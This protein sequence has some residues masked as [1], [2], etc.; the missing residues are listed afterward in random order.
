MADVNKDRFEARLQAIEAKTKPGKR[1][2]QR[3]T[4]DGLVVDIVKSDRRALLPIKSLIAAAVIFIAFK[5]FIFA[6]LGESEYLKRIDTLSGGSAVEVAAAF[7]LDV[8]PV[9]RVVGQLLE[10]TLQ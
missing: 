3:V 4:D 8:D 10:D 2:E 5:G 1:V 7:L 9:T 6:Q